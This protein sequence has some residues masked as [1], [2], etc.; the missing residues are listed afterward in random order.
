MTL[1]EV[2]LVI[3]VL[4]FLAMMLT[5]TLAR[6]R[7]HICPTSCVNNLKQIALAYKVWAGDHNDKFPM[8]LS[9]ANGGTMELMNTPDA[10]KTFQVMSNEVCDPRIIVCPQDSQ[11]GYVTNFK[12]LKG[13]ISYFIAASATDEDPQLFLG[14]D[15]NLLLDQKAVCSGLISVTSASNLI[16][17]GDRHGGY[18]KQGWFSRSKKFGAGNIALTDGSVQSTED[19]NLANWLNETDIYSGRA[20]LI[21]NRLVI[22]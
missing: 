2:I 10:W 6:P 8:E 18:I 15:D 22:P 20:A 13:K 11:H 21:T 12:D 3:L 14:G 9:V 4:A 7:R 17:D 16:W 19:S 5:P 1:F